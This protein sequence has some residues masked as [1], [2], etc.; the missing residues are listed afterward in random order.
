MATTA[1]RWAIRVCTGLLI[2]LVVGYA[3]RG[4]L[5]P[6]RTV[7]VFLQHAESTSWVSAPRNPL[8]EG[9]R[10][11][12]AARDLVQLAGQNLG[13]WHEVATVS[14]ESETPYQAFLARMKAQQSLARYHLLLVE[15]MPPELHFLT[16]LRLRN[17]RDDESV[18][19]GVRAPMEAVI[20]DP[21]YAHRWTELFSGSYR[22]EI[23]LL[24]LNAFND[25]L[26]N[27][28]ND[29]GVDADT[30]EVYERYKE[31]AFRVLGRMGA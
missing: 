29:Q 30:E 22:D 24:N 2:L 13:E 14:F 28:D 8:F 17:F 4:Y 3:I 25:S 1:K 27:Q 10:V 26:D 7:V 20:P 19:V 18:E 5:L 9:G 6:E 15:P 12:F 11:E 16:N 31:K 21:R 23:V